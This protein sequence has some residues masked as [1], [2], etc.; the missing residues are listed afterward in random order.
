[1]KAL[2]SINDVVDEMDVL[3]EE[4]LT[5]SKQTRSLMLKMRVEK[6]Q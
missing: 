4:P 5:G 2:V 6:V 1:M 3:S